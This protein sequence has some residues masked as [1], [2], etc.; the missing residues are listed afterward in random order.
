MAFLLN[1][2]C[3]V[4]ANKI[5]QKDDWR[6]R[7]LTEEMLKYA[8]EDTH[9]LLYI[10]DCIKKQLFIKSFKIERPIF[11]TFTVVMERSKDL[12]LKK[13]F[14]PEIKDYSYYGLI[15][16]NAM[17]LSKIQMSVFKI[18]YKFR[19]YVARKSDCSPDSVLYNNKLFSLAKL[20]E[21]YLV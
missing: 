7:P 20:T 6:I 4:N 21:V 12:C 2:F 9:Y 16:R 3:D 19:D 13:Y 14:K 5:H 15:S 17:I 1:K 11:N 18:L 8:R 10:Y